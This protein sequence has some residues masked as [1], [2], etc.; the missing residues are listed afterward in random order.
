MAPGPT[1]AHMVIM[2]HSNRALIAVAAVPNIAWITFVVGLGV[3]RSLRGEAAMTEG[4]GPAMVG[5]GVF[6]AI[7]CPVLANYL[8]PRVLQP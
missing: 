5:V 8:R 3:W 4:A 7:A 2:T 1:H 6:L